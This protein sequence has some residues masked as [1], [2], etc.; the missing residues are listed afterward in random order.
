MLVTYTDRGL[1]DKGRAGTLD[2]LSLVYSKLQ[3]WNLLAEEVDVAI[4]MDTDVWVQKSMDSQF[5]LLE[6]G[7]L[8]GAFRGNANFPL[9]EPRPAESIRTWKKPHW[10]GI[11]GGVVVLIPYR[12]TFHE[13]IDHLQGYRGPTNA[14]GEQDFL[15]EFFGVVRNTLVQMDVSYNFQIHP[16]ALTGQQA[17][18]EGRWA[19][20]IYVPDSVNV[21][22][23]STQ[24]KP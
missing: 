23:F 20:L 3:I 21:M 13:L 22:H 17:E 2:R 1:R 14:G 6:R 15:S 11:N 9:T 12:D 4:M 18:A 24:P 5:S 8:A 10:G 7:E 19:R 16:L